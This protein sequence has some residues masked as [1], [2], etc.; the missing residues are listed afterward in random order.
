[1]EFV[2]TIKISRIEGLKLINA[3]SSLGLIRNLSIVIFNSISD[4]Q[5]GHFFS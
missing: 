1:M 4:P 2:A 5:D 3:Q